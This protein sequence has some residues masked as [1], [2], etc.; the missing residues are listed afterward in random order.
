MN[1]AIKII[2]LILFSTKN[3]LSLE[4]V[5]NFEE[6]YQNGD[7]QQGH[8]LIKENKIRYQYNDNNLYTIL[9]TQGDFYLI[10]NIYPDKFM[11]I[12]QNTETLIGIEMIINDYP[13]LKSEYKINKVSIKPE[14]KFDDNFLKKITILSDQ[15]NMNIYFP[16]CYQTS[17]QDRYFFYSPFFSFKKND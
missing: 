11:K 2:F 6:V 8:L 14:M 10:E 12:D 15:M 17:I 7:I 9:R 5:C 3:L 13:K 1:K 16:E 4:M